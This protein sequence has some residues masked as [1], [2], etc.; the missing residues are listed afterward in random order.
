M[1]P[2]SRLPSLAPWSQDLRIA[3]YLD[4]PFLAE[5]LRT[6]NLCFFN[7]SL[8]LIAITQTVNIVELQKPWSPNGEDGLG[9]RGLL[10]SVAFRCWPGLQLILHI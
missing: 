8:S 5:I 2:A 3:L 9:Q 1:G 7:H 4:T 6:P 10:L